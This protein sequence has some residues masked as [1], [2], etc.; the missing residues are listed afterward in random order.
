M[1]YINQC[2]SCN[3]FEFE[4]DNRKGYCSY[5]KAF[6]YPG[7][8]CSHYTK[9]QSCYITT[10]IC[11][12][13]GYSDNCEILNTLRGF[14]ND[15][16]QKDPKY[17]EILFEYD[18]VGPHIA[19]SI[20][21]ER[22]YELINGLLDAYILPVVDEVRE[23]KY[24]KAV[25]KYVKMTKALEDYYGLRFIQGDMKDYDYTQGGHGKV[26]KLGTYPTN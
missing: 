4:G 21:E 19:N 26:I 6:Y 11:D 22:D 23:K 9:G 14:R 16:M 12:M 18:T 7:D 20:R 25:D 15:V 3:Y 1:A 10:M 8:S 17:K 24:D 5:Y 2:G 13:L